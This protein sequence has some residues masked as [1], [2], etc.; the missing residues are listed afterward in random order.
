[1]PRWRRGTRQ[2]A[3]QIVEYLG[4]VLDDLPLPVA[5]VTYPG[6]VYA[7]SNKANTALLCT[8]LGPSL[9]E[10]GFLGK[11]I[12][13]VPQFVTSTTYMG[14]LREAAETGETVVG[15]LWEAA[16]GPNGDPQVYK[17]YYCPLFR[18]GTGTYVLRIAADVTGEVMAKRDAEKSA[19]DIISL[20]ANVAEGVTIRDCRGRLVLRNRKADEITGI[21]AEQASTVEGYKLEMY[22][23]DGRRVPEEERVYHRIMRGETIVDEE[24][25]LKR[26]DGQI[27]HIVHTSGALKDTDGNVVLTVTTFH[28]VTEDREQQRARDAFLSSFSRELQ[29]PLASVKSLVG[30][31]RQGM[32]ERKPD[33]VE[34][35]LSRAEAELARVSGLVNEIH[36]GYRVASGQLALD[37]KPV[38]LAQVIAEVVSQG[39]PGRSTHRLLI[40]P[41]PTPVQVMGDAKRLAEVLTHLLTNAFNYS[42]DGTRVWVDVSVEGASTF[43]R[44]QDEGIGI[45]Q[46]ELD[47]VFGGFHRGSNLTKRDPGGVGLGLFVSREVARRHGGDLWAE[48]RA[49]GGTVL[50]LRLPLR[51]QA[52]STPLG[53]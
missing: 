31:S 53:E 25:V 3:K 41:M 29:K 26:V 49:G 15:G 18:D 42:P 11:A 35:Y 13:D 6:F 8:A 14:A 32:A 22:Y 39:L 10:E 36:T 12:P 44:I 24:F 37:H 34:S 9:H 45:P 19:L 5:V 27:R 23:P 46:G 40:A 7:V 16:S 51:T 33:E 2:D 52:A 50:I 20:L 43:V 47:E 28:D 1:M 17:M 21:S 48:H 4:E 38:D 30:K